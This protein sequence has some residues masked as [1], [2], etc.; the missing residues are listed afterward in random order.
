MSRSPQRARSDYKARTLPDGDAVRPHD[1]GAGLH[2]A[3][4]AIRGGGPSFTIS[5]PLEMGVDG[6]NDSSQ[7]IYGGLVV[8]NVDRVEFDDDRI[9]VGSP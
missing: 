9:L 4:Q 3:G 8:G 6:I 1:R 5:V 2:G 7:I